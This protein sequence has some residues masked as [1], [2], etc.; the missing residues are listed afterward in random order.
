MV[1]RKLLVIGLIS[2]NAFGSQYIKE[3]TNLND[4]I[5]FSTTQQNIETEYTITPKKAMMEEVIEV[6]KKPEFTSLSI[7]GEKAAKSM[8]T[9]K[10]NQNQSYLESRSIV[11][12]LV[13]EIIEE[14]EFASFLIEGEKATKSMASWEI[15][16]TL[17]AKGSSK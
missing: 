17:K 9:W 11:E 16:Y 13:I 10:T 4:S 7:K 14:P 2:T 6:L 5:H 8:S 3:V 12:V 1:I 15:M